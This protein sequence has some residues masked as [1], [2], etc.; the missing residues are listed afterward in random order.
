MKG[1]TIMLFQMSSF[2]N[3][4]CIFVGKKSY[5]FRARQDQTRTSEES[6]ASYYKNAGPTL[7]TLPV[8]L[9]SSKIGRRLDEEQ[10]REQAGFRKRFSTMD[11][12]HT[13]TRLIEVS[14]E[15]KKPLCLTFIDLK[16][17]FDSVET[18]AVMEVLT[19]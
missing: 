9:Q 3:P 2:R 8:R 16:K 12:I 11:H 6:T 18:G 17:A 1:K 5:S 10:S 14:R 13:I 19:N 15:Y 4:T 7:H